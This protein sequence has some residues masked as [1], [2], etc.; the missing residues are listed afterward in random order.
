MNFVKP[1]W[2]LS[3]IALL[4]TNLLVYLNLAELTGPPAIY[5]QETEGGTAFLS[6]NVL[7]WL[8]VAVALISNGV[9]NALGSMLPFANFGIF[10]LPQKHYWF[11]SLQHRKKLQKRTIATARW[12]CVLIN[13]FLILILRVIYLSNIKEPFDYN[14]LYFL[15]VLL[16]IIWLLHSYSQLNK[17]PVK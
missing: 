11:A 12:L 2:V 13:L 3:L 4:G 8:T 17:L 9:L 15:F 1:L 10:P 5:F 16:F 6:R 14:G 7:F